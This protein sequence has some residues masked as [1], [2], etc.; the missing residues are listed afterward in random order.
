M[1]QNAALTKKAESLTSELR[2]AK[3]KIAKLETRLEVTGKK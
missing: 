1:E 2:D 3:I